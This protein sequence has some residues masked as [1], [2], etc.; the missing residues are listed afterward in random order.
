MDIM[1]PEHAALPQCSGA[2]HWRFRTGWELS[3]LS[4]RGLLAVPNYPK[5]ISRFV[6]WHHG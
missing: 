1:D 5:L 2:G 6:L 4:L 3:S